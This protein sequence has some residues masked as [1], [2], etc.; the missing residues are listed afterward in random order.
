MD[1][2]LHTVSVFMLMCRSHADGCSM[3]ICMHVC[4]HAGMHQLSNVCAL[5]VDVWPQLPAAE[6]C[7]VQYGHTC[8]HSAAKGGHIEVVKYLCEVG[9]KDLIMRLDQVRCDAICVLVSC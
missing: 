6:A 4:M 9:G 8:L 1:T 7:P 3:H 5:N 2:K